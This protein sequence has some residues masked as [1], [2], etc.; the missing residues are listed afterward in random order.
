MFL[1]DGRIKLERVLEQASRERAY[2]PSVKLEKKLTIFVRGE[3]N[4]PRVFTINEAQIEINF[5]I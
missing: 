5:E 1:N 4:I 3:A 2:L